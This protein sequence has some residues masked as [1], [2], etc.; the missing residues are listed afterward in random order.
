[1]IRTPLLILLLVLSNWTTHAYPCPEIVFEY[2][3]NDPVD[4]VHH[5][6]TVKWT[7]N[8]GC[9]DHDQRSSK[10]VVQIQ[11]IFDEVLLMDTVEGFS[12]AIKPENLDSATGLS[13]FSVQ[14]L[15]DEDKYSVALKT[16]TSD[17]GIPQNLTERL[18]AFL[19]N[20]Y[21]LNALTVLEQLSEEN[22]LPEIS[23]QM[24]LM[25]PANYPD[26][27]DFFN[28]YLST[29]TGALIT[30]PYV[31][32]LDEFAKDLN[33]GTKDDF[34][35]G[36]PFDIELLISPNNQ[37]ISIAIGSTNY[38]PLIRELISKLSF[39]STQNENSLVLIKVN[40]S[41]NGKKYLITNERAL[42]NPSSDGFRK[43]YPYKGAIH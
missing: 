22:L 23:E 4:I 34:I 41:E 21:F 37:I 29:E 3:C 30:M 15:G 9:E 8:T 38:E 17:Q 25:F 28:S 12:Y 42:I 19:L 36:N 31:N 13:V 39:Q 14:E 1:M 11:N 2:I 24:D 40:K 10:F 20:G 43:N 7:Y 32:G 16:N 35:K 18:N 26:N 6:L 5:E 27:C 33:K